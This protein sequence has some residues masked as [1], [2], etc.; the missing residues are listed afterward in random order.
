MPIV[1]LT[2]RVPAE[3]ATLAPAR[4]LV[5]VIAPIEPVADAPVNV[6]VRPRLLDPADVAAETPASASEI[7]SAEVID[8]AVLVDCA[9][10]SVTPI[11]SASDPLDD[12][13]ALPENASET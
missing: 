9:P 3:L 1:A 2:A 6:I 4:G 13:A 10:V 7:D 11:D 5:L 8:P 12:V